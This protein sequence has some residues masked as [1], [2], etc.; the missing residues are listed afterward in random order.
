MVLDEGSA[1]LGQFLWCGPW[2]PPLK[3]LQA[4]DLSLSRGPVPL[5][6][7]LLLAATREE[8][9]G[10]AT[11]PPGP[12]TRRPTEITVHSVDG[13]NHL[14]FGACQYPLMGTRV[15]FGSSVCW[16]RQLVEV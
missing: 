11:K 8:S 12:F 2:V 15:R 9:P 5:N 13:I 6:L 7:P 16:L 1:C 4:L 14:L 10:S 3:E